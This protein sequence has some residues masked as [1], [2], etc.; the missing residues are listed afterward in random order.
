MPVLFRF[1]LLFSCVSFT[2]PGVAQPVSPTT[3]N[4]RLAALINDPEIAEIS[5]LATSRLHPNVIWVHN[6]SFD[7]PVLH[8]LSTAGKRLANVT[9][10]GVEKI[11][12]ASGRERV[13]QYV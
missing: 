3:G 1:A 2:S 6:D 12:R 9:I 13:C 7:K 11:G 10:A 4:S 8:A 5:G